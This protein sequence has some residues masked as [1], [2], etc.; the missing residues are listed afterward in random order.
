MPSS[1]PPMRR[2]LL[3]DASPYIFRSYFALPSSIRTPSGQPANA[4]NGFASFLVKLLT[5]EQPSHV[6]IAFDGSLTTSFRNEIYPEYKANRELPPTELVQQVED[7]RHL[8]EALGLHTAISDRYEADDLIGS[9]L[10]QVSWQPKRNQSDDT[11]P[12]SVVSSDKDLGQLVSAHVDFYDF[13]KGTRLGPTGI[14]AKFGVPPR[15]IV[16]FLALAGDSVDN[17]PGVRGVGPKTA[18][19]LLTEFESLSEILDNL[20]A[21]AQLPL[22]GA[23]GIAK[24]LAEH[25]D[26]ARI[27]HRLAALAVDAPVNG[28][29]AAMAWHGPTEDWPTVCGRLGFTSLLDRGLSLGRS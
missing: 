7:C 29:P 27:S 17:I 15:K 22:R 28:K 2:V 11:A 12:I 10:H 14:E 1:T 13:A 25:A 23:K 21:I 3:V 6:G 16:D 4:S 5:E 20:D 18:V 8:A 19:T 9:W 26:T 24:K